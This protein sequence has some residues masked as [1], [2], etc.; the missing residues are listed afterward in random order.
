MFN[1]LEDT[2]SELT[3]AQRREKLRVG[4]HRRGE[5]RTTRAEPEKKGQTGGARQLFTKRATARRPIGARG[6]ILYHIWKYATPSRRQ[7]PVD[8][9]STIKHAEGIHRSPGPPAKTV[10]LVEYFLR[11]EEIQTCRK[12]QTGGAESRFSVPPP[13][14]VSRRILRSPA[15][16]LSVGRRL[17]SSS[18]TGAETRFGRRLLPRLLVSIRRRLGNATYPDP[19]QK[20]R[21]PTFFSSKFFPGEGKPPKDRCTVT[22]F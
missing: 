4:R 8:L 13:A 10:S 16:S 2:I 20:R 22:Y 3:A 12:W 15:F 19:L 7:K 5:E 9:T 6:A 11:V 17:S 21:D 14:T 1:A 18:P